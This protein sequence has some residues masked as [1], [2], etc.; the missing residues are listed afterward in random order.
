MAEIEITERKTRA[1]V[2]AYLREFAEKL[3]SGRKVTLM[4]GNE[5]ATVNPP[6]ELS[7]AVEVDSDTSLIGTE[8]THTVAFDLAWEDEE[9]EEDDGMSIK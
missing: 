2:A 3:E 8:P 6:K 7:F 5:S 9:V 4:V 1:E